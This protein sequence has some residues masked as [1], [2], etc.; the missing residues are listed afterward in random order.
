MDPHPGSMT[1]IMIRGRKKDTILFQEKRDRE[2]T[3]LGRMM[4][5]VLPDKKRDKA[6]HDRMRDTA[7]PERMRE[8]VPHDKSE[9]VLPATMTEL[10]LLGSMTEVEVLEMKG[11]TIPG[12]VRETCS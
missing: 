4:D 12:M 1:E 9:F 7:L 11:T 10:A 3:H 8:M 6:L 5:M 2:T